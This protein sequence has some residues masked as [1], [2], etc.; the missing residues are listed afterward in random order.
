ML[1]SANV[2][3]Y[4]PPGGVVGTLS[5]SDLK[6]YAYNLYLGS[7]GVTKVTVPWAFLCKSQLSAP[8]QV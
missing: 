2:H 3:I 6:F 5:L 1:T 8:L 7:W 4:L